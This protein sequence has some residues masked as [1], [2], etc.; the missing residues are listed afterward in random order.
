VI[1][2]AMTTHFVAVLAAA[3]REDNPLLRVN[4]GLWLW[5]ILIFLGLAFVLWRFGWRVM[6]SK[7]DTRD[8]AIRGA[9]EEARKQRDEA[10][11]VLAEQREVLSRTRRETSEMLNAAQN[12]AERERQRIVNEARG[13]YDKLVARGREQIAQ[14]TRAAIEEVRR[15]T[16]SL[17]LDVASKVIGR[18]LDAPAQKELAD[19][20]VRDLEKM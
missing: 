1:A 6:I 16:A 10:E 20:F 3:A 14:E 15:T 19:K 13:E 11:R 4:P 8:Q 9:I 18:T 2:M 7:L 12:Q 5:T 17:A